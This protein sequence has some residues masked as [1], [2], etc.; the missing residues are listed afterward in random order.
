MEREVL[1]LNKLE[2][3][4]IAKADDVFFGMAELAYDSDQKSDTGLTVITR[5][6]SC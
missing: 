1:A 5:V 4:Y 3:H 2:Y 6:Y